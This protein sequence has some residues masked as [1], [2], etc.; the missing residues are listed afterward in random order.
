MR[1]NEAKFMK[2][3]EALGFQGDAAKFF[4]RIAP[5]S[6]RHWDTAGSGT[7]GTQYLLYK[8]LWHQYDIN[9]TEKAAHPWITSPHPG[10]PLA[11][12]KRTDFG[13]SQTGF[14]FGF[15]HALPGKKKNAPSQVV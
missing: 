15:H 7:Y 9:D 11:R 13:M 4:R 5:E 2:G 3:C 6:M 8:D 14:D 12:T 1:V 10:S